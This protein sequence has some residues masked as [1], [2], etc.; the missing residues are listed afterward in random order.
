MPDR[1]ISGAEIVDGDL[2]AKFLE[3]VQLSHCARVVVDERGLGDFEGHR[4]WVDLRRVQRLA[5]ALGKVRLVEL[6]TRDVYRNAQF[7]Q[8]RALLPF[9]Y[10]T[11]G[12]MQNPCADLED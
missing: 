5:D 7:R 11:A 8:L 10:L 12:V 9:V 6:A 2:D 4:R 1:R 3:R